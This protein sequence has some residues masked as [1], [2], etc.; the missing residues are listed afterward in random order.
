MLIHR[1]KG[2]CLFGSPNR[3][4]RPVCNRRIDDSHRYSY[5]PL[6]GDYFILIYLYVKLYPMIPLSRP[7][8][9]GF[10]GPIQSA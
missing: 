4:Y 10:S 9:V 7:T 3:R 5:S 6:V 1:D 8:G 2:L